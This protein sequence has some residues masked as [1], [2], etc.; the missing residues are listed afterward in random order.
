MGTSSLLDIIGSMT[1]AGLL[2]LMTLRLNASATEYSH[3]YYSNYILQANLVTAVLMIE[4][5][6]KHIGYCRNP[7]KLSTADAIVTAEA[8]KIAYCTDLNNN[9]K[10]DTVTYWAG[11]PSEFAGTGSPN[12]FYLYRQENK[13]PPTKWNLGLTRFRL[14]Y[15]DNQNT[16][17]AMSFPI[18]S[19]GAIRV[20]DLSIRLETP[21][22][23]KLGGG[24]QYM[25]RADTA[26]YQLYWRELRMTS[27]AFKFPRSR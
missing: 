18:A 4:N 6:F 16:P 10:V 27:V 25:Q 12:M 15:W 23:F 17:D 11:D 19:V 14:T 21:Y 3:A 20:T 5:D 26:E 1:I 2:L 8:T 24:Q 7:A 9:G 22:S 13:K